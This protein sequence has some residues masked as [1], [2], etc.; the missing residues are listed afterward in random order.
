MIC[1][2]RK[3]NETNCYNKIKYIILKQRLKLASNDFE[4]YLICQKKLVGI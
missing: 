4:E 1:E 2:L 3:L